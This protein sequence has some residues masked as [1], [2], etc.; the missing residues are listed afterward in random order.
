MFLNFNCIITADYGLSIS[1]ELIVKLLLTSDCG[2]IKAVNCLDLNLTLTHIPEK[3]LLKHKRNK[4][5]CISRPHEYFV[6]EGLKGFYGLL[7]SLF[8]SLRYT[9]EL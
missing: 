5:E 2:S 9:F 8:S 6:H 4:C 1:I 7:T 3:R